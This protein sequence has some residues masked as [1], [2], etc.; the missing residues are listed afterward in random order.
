MTP[1]FETV[2]QARAWLGSQ[3]EL[4][5]GEGTRAPNVDSA[6][7]YRKIM[8]RLLKTGDP[9]A[10]ASNTT[11]KSTYFKRRAAILHCL[12]DVIEV[13]LKE[14]DQLQR[15]NGLSDPEKRAK[16]DEHVKA[17]RYAM[18]LVGRIPDDHNIKEISPRETKRKNL[19]KLPVNWREKLMDRMPKYEAAMAV[20]ALTGCRPV[21]LKKFGAAVSFKEGKLKI[22]IL[23]AKLGENSGQEWREMTFDMPTDNPIA[24]RLGRLVLMNRDDLLVN[25]ES[26]MNFTTSIR[27]AGRRA[28]PS[29]PDSITAYSLRHQVASDLKASDLSPDQVSQALGHSS[30][31]TK[32]SYGIYSQGTGTMAPGKV[33]AQRPVKNKPVKPLPGVIKPRNGPHRP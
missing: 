6:A 8:A 15:N 30:G 32:G 12:R 2:K 16:W 28:F 14:Q 13:R 27:S 17:L 10:A 21:E 4:R 25:I 22:L 33:E 23:G 11:K 26:E 19:S 20:A 18:H 31:D 1:D 5:A 29:F 9:W 3:A 24:M 7:D